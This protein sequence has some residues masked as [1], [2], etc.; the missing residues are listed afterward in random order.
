MPDQT[1]HQRASH[2]TPNY[3]PLAAVMGIHARELG[4]NPA[5]ARALSSG[6]FHVAFASQIEAERYLVELEAE[7]FTELKT[8]EEG[9]LVIATGKA[10]NPNLCQE[11]A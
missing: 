10:W 7:R 6:E 2:A 11:S 8:Y 5:K 3:G 9:G 1:I 4:L